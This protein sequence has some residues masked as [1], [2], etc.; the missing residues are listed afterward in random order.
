MH[1][2]PIFTFAHLKGRSG[3]EIQNFHISNLPCGL[4]AC[5]CNLKVL[6]IEPPA[7]VLQATFVPAKAAA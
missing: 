1:N 5:I 4:I 6:A 3:L 7:P 2:T